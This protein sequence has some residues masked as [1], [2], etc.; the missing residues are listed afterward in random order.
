MLPEYSVVT[1]FK[2]SEEYILTA[3]ESIF[4]QTH[5]PTDVY[6]INDHSADS[7]HKSLKELQKIFNFKILDSELNGQKNAMWKG[8][9][10]VKT[11]YVSFLDS[12]DSWAPDKQF[13]QITEF[14]ENN[15]IDIVCSGVRNFKSNQNN[16]LDFTRFSKVFITSRMFSASTFRHRLF[17]DFSSVVKSSSHFQWQLEWWEQA[18]KLGYKVTQT[19]QIHLFRRIHSENSWTIPDN[20]GKADLFKFLRKNIAG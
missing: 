9:Q 14:Q 2:N 11:D 15:D 18:M 5:K 10:Q 1:A 8:L 16:K 7:A 13:V 4:L 6:V 12:D 17:K 3:L 20:D 19:N